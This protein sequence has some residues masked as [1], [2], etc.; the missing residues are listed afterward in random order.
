MGDSYAS[1]RLPGVHE[2]VL[3]LLADDIALED[4]VGA[5]AVVVPADHGRRAVDPE[6]LGHPTQTLHWRSSGQTAGQQSI[7]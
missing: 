2:G 1:Y 7:N 5:A 6:P 3:E 4:G